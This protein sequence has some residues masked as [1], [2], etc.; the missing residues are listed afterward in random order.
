MMALR[1]E[2]PVEQV[3]QIAGNPVIEEERQ[4]ASSSADPVM[5]DNEDAPVARARKPP[6]TVKKDWE[7]RLMEARY[8]GQHART[9]AMIGMTADGIFCRRLGR[10]LPEIER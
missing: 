6:G 3:A 9:G 5:Q 7:P 2:Q 4:R 1:R 8:L 10:R